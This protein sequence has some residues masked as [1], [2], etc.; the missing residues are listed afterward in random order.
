MGKSTFLRSPPKQKIHDSPFSVM[1]IVN[2]LYLISKK[3][4]IAYVYATSQAVY[5]RQ[6]CVDFFLME[7]K[8]IKEIKYLLP[9]AYLKRKRENERKP[10]L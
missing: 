2:K 6:K 9:V 7:K 5:V 3:K 1:E 10:P 8:N 4:S